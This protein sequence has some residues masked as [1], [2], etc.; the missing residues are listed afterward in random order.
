MFVEKMEK[1]GTKIARKLLFVLLPVLMAVAMLPMPTALY[2]SDLSEKDEPLPEIYLTTD[3]GEIVDSKDYYKTGRMQ[4]KLT[5]RFAGYTNEYT[6]DGGAIKI[7]CRGNSTFETSDKRLGE[8]A[9]YSYKVKLD[10]KADLLGMGKSKHWVLIANYYDV[11]NMRNK[12]TYDLSGRMGLTYTKSRWVVVYLN[13]EYR[14]I[15]TLCENVRIA[16]GR[17]DIPDWEDRAEDVADA[18]A[19]KEGYDKEV[20]EKLGDEMK[21]NL[22][23]VTSGEFRSSASGKIT[24]YT[25]SK[26]YD[27][28]DFDITSG[29]LIE[30]DMRMDSDCTKFY[31]PHGKPIQ[32]DNP[33]ALETN[34]EMYDYVVKLLSDFEEAIY[35]PN[36]CTADGRHYSEFIDMDSFIDYHIVF[37]L[38]K[39]IEFGHLSIFFYINNGKIY[40]GPCWDFDGGCGN[41][42]T[43]TKEWMPANSWFYMGGRAEWWIKMI[44]DPYY[45]ALLEDRWAEVRDLVDEMLDSM[46]IYNDYIKAESDRDSAKYGMPKNWYMGGGCKDYTSEFETLK[47]WMNQRVS[48][49]DRQWVKHDPNMENSG[50][51]CSDRI[52][53]KLE[54][55]SGG[56]LAADPY[57]VTGYPADFA[58]DLSSGSDLVLTVSTTHTSH[59]SAEIYVNGKLILKEAF[60]MNGKN[61]YVIPKSALSAE[62]GAINVITLIGI[63]TNGDYYQKS[64]VAVRSRSEVGTVDDNSAVLLLQGNK[65]SVYAKSTKITLPATGAVEKGYICIGWTDGKN[66]YPAGSEYTVSRNA[67]LY[68]KWERTNF[69]PENGKDPS[70]VNPPDNQP[71]NPSDN[72]PTGDDG[73]S[74]PSVIMPIVIG[75]AALLCVAAVVIVL[76]VKRKK[77]TG[78]TR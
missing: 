23:W 34:K 17:V 42:V 36:F 12:L 38:F 2:A 48:W 1:C 54:Y 20:A 46:D 75:S 47:K 33:S 45:I 8:N 69:F 58:Y 78:K 66:V 61:R 65:P 43:L 28:S 3:D 71:D 50:I 53:M 67:Y 68:R 16:S 24:K 18:I 31:T 37:N 15:Y 10:K 44:G 76:I 19:E 64:Y 29:Y 40:F 14:G 56:T 57:A 11:T 7:R 35:S 5:D 63:N 25:V 32:I 9:K 26:Y 49:L 21:N 13:G 62:D 30:Y 41:Q 22:S 72:Q 74:K 27:T 55:A 52:T 4:M 6:T 51:K 39:N 77:T 59:K 70:P 73:K 60:E